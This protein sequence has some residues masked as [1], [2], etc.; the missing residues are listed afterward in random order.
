MTYSGD[1]KNAMGLTPVKIDGLLYPSIAVN[2]NTDNIALKPEYVDKNLRFLQVDLLK[3]VKKEGNKVR[4]Q[5]FDVA[6]QISSR[7]EVLW[8][9]FLGN[10]T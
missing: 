8:T 10:G 2:G 5:P 4:I 9:G 6:Q 3:V 1:S 7:G